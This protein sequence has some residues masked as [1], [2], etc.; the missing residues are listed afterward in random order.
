MTQSS[1][2]PIA[3]IAAGP[4]DETVGATDQDTSAGCCGTEPKKE[5][6]M[7]EETMT[8]TAVASACCGGPAPKDGEACCVKDADA[9]AAGQSGCGC[10]TTLVEEKVAPVAAA[11]ACCR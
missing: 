11:A 1:D 9:K 3:V 5:E 7:A 10:G 8:R 2:F 6:M 4:V